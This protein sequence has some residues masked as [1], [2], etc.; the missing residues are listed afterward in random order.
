M[1]MRSGARRQFELSDVFFADM[2]FSMHKPRV[3]KRKIK[4]AEGLPRNLRS[5]SV[6]FGRLPPAFFWSIGLS[7]GVHV[8]FPGCRIPGK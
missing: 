4:S 8:S 7:N 5:D 1:E 3:S 2:L 6:L